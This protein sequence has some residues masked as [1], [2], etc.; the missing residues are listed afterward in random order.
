MW[1][2]YLGAYYVPIAKSLES[3]DNHRTYFT[4]AQ[5]HFRRDFKFKRRFHISAHQPERGLDP[6]KGKVTIAAADLSCERL[7]Q[8]EAKVRVLAVDRRFCEE[9]PGVF[10][11][12]NRIAVRAVLKNKLSGDRA[13]KSSDD[14]NKRIDCQVMA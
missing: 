4:V 12:N 5:G 7:V 14:R 9:D 8:F 13:E 3:R 10:G 11:S 2:K 1:V 6:V